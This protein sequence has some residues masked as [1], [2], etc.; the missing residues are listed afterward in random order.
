MSYLI[1]SY[2]TSPLPYMDHHQRLIYQLE[3]SKLP[4]MTHGK[5]FVLGRCQ[6]KEGTSLNPLVAR[7]SPVDV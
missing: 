4:L 3:L 6:C 1:F 7:R 5:L 2:S